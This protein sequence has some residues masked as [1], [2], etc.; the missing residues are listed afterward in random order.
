MKTIAW[1][2]EQVLSV[3][4]RETVQPLPTPP[5]K[6]RIN[7]GSNN[8]TLIL[9]IRGNAK[10]TQTFP[11]TWESS[12]LSYAFQFAFHRIEIYASKTH[13]WKM[14]E[15]EKINYPVCDELGRNEDH[16][17]WDTRIVTIVPS[18]T[19]VTALY[20]N[21]YLSCSIWHTKQLN[22]IQLLSYWMSNNIPK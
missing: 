17:F 11:Q 19:Q 22:G 7:Y 1:N 16:S 9:L 15:E 4:G 8:Q 13:E 20:S 21:C 6:R 18:S 14:K 2:N 12:F 3:D 10:P 5:D